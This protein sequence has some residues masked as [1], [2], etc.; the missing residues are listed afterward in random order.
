MLVRH[1]TG[2]PP[3]MATKATALLESTAELYLLDVVF[4]ECI[5]V[6]ESYYRTT[7]A[8]V[9]AL[10]QAALALPAVQVI[11]QPLLARALE[12]YEKQ[13]L[14]FA[15]AYLVAAAEVSGIGNIASFDEAIDGVPSVTRVT[16]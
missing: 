16:P 6:L 13:R 9:A 15:E 1:L 12:V 4:A 3:E 7:R 8:Q 5:Y 2:D 14:D 10:M 11:A